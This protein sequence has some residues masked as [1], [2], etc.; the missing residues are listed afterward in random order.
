MRITSQESLKERTDSLLLQ[1]CRK[2]SGFFL[3]HPLSFSQCRF[4]FFVSLSQLVE[5]PLLVLLALK[6]HTLSLAPLG[7]DAGL[8]RVQVV[9]QLHPR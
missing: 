2:L 8:R 9:F 6:L 7:H 1:S 5:L 3:E 4:V